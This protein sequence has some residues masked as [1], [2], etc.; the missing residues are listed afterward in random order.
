MESGNAGASG[1]D[2]PGLRLA[3]QARGLTRQQLAELA[4]VTRQQVFNV[5]SGKGV[6]RCGPRWP[7]P[8]P[9]G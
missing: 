2:D 1:N 3:R 6:S 8:A 7:W 4:G 9:R 5:E